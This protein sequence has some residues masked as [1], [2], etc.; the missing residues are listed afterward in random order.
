MPIYVHTTS[1]L[2][3][4]TH[5]TY[6]YSQSTQRAI[7]TTT[8]RPSLLRRLSIY[9]RCISKNIPDVIDCTS[10]EDCQ[11]LITFGTATNILDKTGHQVTIQ[12]ITLLSVCFCT[13]WENPDSSY[14]R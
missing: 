2:I 3:G 4:R 6:S 5:S 8:A 13:T 10:E 14:N 9:S 12:V 7:I 1:A 11:I